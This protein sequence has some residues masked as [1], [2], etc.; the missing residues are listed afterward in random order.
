[1]CLGGTERPVVFLYAYG[2]VI[3]MWF[4]H[5]LLFTYHFLLLLSIVG[6]A[7]GDLVTLK[8]G[9]VVEGEIAYEGDDVVVT[10]PGGGAIV[11]KPKDVERVESAISPL[12]IFQKKLSMFQDDADQ[13]VTLAKWALRKNMSNEYVL[14]LRMAL[15]VQQ[16]HAEATHLL[17]DFQY[18]R[19]RLPINYVAS[20]KLLRELGGDFTIERTAHFRVAYNGDYLYAKTS[21]DRMEDVYRQF[22]KFFNLRKFHPVPLS[23]RLEVV[24]FNNKVTFSAYA[25]R[26]SSGF[27]LKAIKNLG[28]YYSPDINR[29]HFYDIS[30]TEQHRHTVMQQLSNINKLKENIEEISRASASSRFKLTGGESG[31]DNGTLSSIPRDEA[32]LVLKSS[33]KKMVL[34]YDKIVKGANEMNIALC[35]HELTHHLAFA[36][37]I[38]NN[39]VHNPKWITEGLATYF[40]SPIYGNWF[41]P[42]EVHAEK[43]KLFITTDQSYMFVT[44][45]ELIGDDEMFDLAHDRSSDGYAAAWSLFYFLTEKHHEALF[46]YMYDLSLKVGTGEYRRFS[47]LE[48]FEKY[49]GKIETLNKQWRNYMTYLASQTR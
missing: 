20:D 43:L 38:Q 44:M 36:C 1:L 11:F 16:G 25:K 26:Q 17:A 13:C 3:A 48:D 7:C 18:R 12:I 15:K 5:F 10:L 14:A 33:L 29:S 42:G 9:E 23:D 47:R 19:Q 37:G 46:D 28:G 34:H 35:V 39:Q 2:I 22:I 49:F 41:G 32:M 30:N 8:S 45:D 31:H 6:V 21:A 24:L 4:K 27:S 40:E